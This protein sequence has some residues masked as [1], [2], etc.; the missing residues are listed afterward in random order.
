MLRTRDGYTLQIQPSTLAKIASQP[1]RSGLTNLIRRNHRGNL[2]R[3]TARSVAQLARNARR[4]GSLYRSKPG[5]SPILFSTQVNGRRYQI[6]T[7][8]LAPAHIAVIA[9]R[10]QS[11][12]VGVDR[13]S[14]LGTG[15]ALQRI[16]NGL[17]RKSGIRSMAVA[18]QRIRLGRRQV[19]AGGI[20]VGTNR[21]DISYRDR[22]GCRVNIE[23]DTSR[24]T[25]SRHEIVVNG[26]DP[27]ALNYFILIDP[28]TGEITQAVRIFK[29]GES[30]PESKSWT[31]SQF[32]SQLPKVETARQKGR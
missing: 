26:R 1:A 11:G 9:I 23:L 25:S 29:P 19:D 31:L 28:W 32:I 6:I 16:Y 20:Q 4:T 22:K 14:G 8:P 17:K 27:N 5:R 21:P 30:R 12:W 10:P 2:K 7:K 3:A 18:R 24:H 15:I 13:E